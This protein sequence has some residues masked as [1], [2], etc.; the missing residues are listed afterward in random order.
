MIAPGS[1]TVTAGARS[2]CTDTASARR[3]RRDRA[4][5]LT[6]ALRAP[7]SAST[8]S[9][10][11]ATSSTQSPR[12]TTRAP[13][14]LGARR[15]GRQRLEQEPRA[16]RSVVPARQDRVVEHEQRHDPLG[17]A[18]G[19]SERRMIRDA[20]VAGEHDHRHRRHVGTLPRNRASGSR[21][22]EGVTSA[23]HRPRA[24]GDPREREELRTLA[25]AERMTVATDEQRRVVIEGVRRPRGRRGRWCRRRRRGDAAVPAASASSTDGSGDRFARSTRAPGPTSEQ[26]SS[27]RGTRRGSRR[28]G[29]RA[30]RLTVGAQQRRSPI[31]AR[32]GAGRGSGRRRAPPRRSRRRPLRSRARA[33]R[34][35][36]RCAAAPRTR[37]PPRRSPCSST[38]MPTM[39]PSTAP[40]RDATRP[41]APGRSGSHTRTSTWRSGTS[42]ASPSRR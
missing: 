40:M 5:P 10:T 29:S 26:R 31:R 4:Y 41:S 6:S 28:R 7:T 8:A 35:P 11:A 9:T 38:S 23:E 20:E 19:A 21:A 30:A 24:V 37:R 15:R 16:V 1:S 3:S 17:V 12:R 27:R 32:R 25:A 2:T 36:R 14:R 34:V 39:S 22:R 18:G 33:G 42:W 13:P